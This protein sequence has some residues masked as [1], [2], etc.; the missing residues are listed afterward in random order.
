MIDSTTME[1]APNN[2]I[3]W[4]GQRARWIKGFI[5]TIYVFIQAKKDYT[6]LGLGS[7]RLIV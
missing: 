3:D 1:E 4:I 7:V 5:Q 6:R 2:L